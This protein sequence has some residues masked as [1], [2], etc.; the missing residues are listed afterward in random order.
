MNGTALK[1]AAFSSA[2]EEII[3]H[4]HGIRERTRITPLPMKIHFQKCRFV[5]KAL[6]MHRRARNITMDAYG[7]AYS[8]V[9]RS[10]IASPIRARNHPESPSL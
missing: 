6:E 10:S 3:F 4:I 7:H 1:M 9:M 2:A 8:V 5:W